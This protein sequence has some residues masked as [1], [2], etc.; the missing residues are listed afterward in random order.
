MGTFLGGMF[1]NTDQSRGNEVVVLRHFFFVRL[2]SLR[3]LCIVVSK[4]QGFE[5]LCN[6]EAQTDCRDSITAWFMARAVKD[7]ETKIP[8][9]ILVL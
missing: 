3:K 1:R 8:E 5:H 2:R 6:E 4:K 9:V 7:R